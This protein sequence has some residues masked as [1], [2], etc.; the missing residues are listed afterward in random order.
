MNVGKV[1]SESPVSKHYGV[2]LGHI[3]AMLRIKDTV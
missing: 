2:L 1:V 3:V